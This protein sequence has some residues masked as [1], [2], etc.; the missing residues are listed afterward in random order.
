MAFVLFEGFR[1]Y[2]L[3]EGLDI[4]IF[5]FISIGRVRMREWRDRL[6]RLGRGGI[7]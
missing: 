3:S 5:I 2:L 4:F 1:S 6:G 7:R